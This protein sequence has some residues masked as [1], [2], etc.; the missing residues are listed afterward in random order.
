M[1][2]E[3]A[4]L[5]KMLRNERRLLSKE[6]SALLREATNRVR[7]ALF[8]HAQSRG[9]LGIRIGNKGEIQCIAP[10]PPRVY[11]VVL[12]VGDMVKSISSRAVGEHR[13]VVDFIIGTGELRLSSKFPISRSDASCAVWDLL[14]RGILSW[15]QS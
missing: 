8:D 4:A 10:K 2:Q 3:R 11:D 1:N 14:S 12:K 6:R 13:V 7:N 9:E 15:R 5:Q